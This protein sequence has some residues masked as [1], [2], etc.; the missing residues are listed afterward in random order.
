MTIPPP[1]ALP[2]HPHSLA[3][4]TLNEMVMSTNVTQDGLRRDSSE[5]PEEE[6]LLLRRS[7]I[8]NRL[9]EI[10]DTNDTVDDDLE[11][12]LF[13]WMYNSQG[14]KKGGTIPPPSRSGGW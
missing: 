14:R 2:F 7:E 5:M 12:C 10:D 8:I 11:R 13:R 1:T 9:K 3:T 6:N 4:A